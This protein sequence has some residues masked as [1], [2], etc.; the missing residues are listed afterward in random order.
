MAD[1]FADAADY[2]GD[3]AASEAPS[4]SAEAEETPR[5]LII[6]AE[7]GDAVDASLP[8]QAPPCAVCPFLDGV[9]RTV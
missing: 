5:T 9:A 8:P 2:F 4:S 3:D 1:P 7:D 6:M